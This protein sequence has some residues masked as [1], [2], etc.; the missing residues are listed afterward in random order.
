MGSASFRTLP[1]VGLFLACAPAEIGNVV[2]PVDRAPEVRIGVAL[3]LPALTLG[4]GGAILLRTPSGETL[5][6]L[7][8]Q[9][10]VPVTAGQQGLRLRGGGSL[11]FP[12][13]ELLLESSEAQGTVRL[14]GREYRG[15]FLISASSGGVRAVNLVDLEEYL[16]G[17][18]GAEMGLRGESE[19]EALRAQA[20]ASRTFAV[21]ALGRWRTRGYDLVST[22]ADQAYAGVGFEY[23]LA[24]QAVRET[25]GQVVSWNDAPIDA[26]FHSTCGGRTA[27]GTEV[28]PNADRPYLRSIRD[29][30]AGGR[31]WCSISPRFRW[32]ESWTSEELARTLAATLPAAGGSAALGRAVRELTIVGRTATGRVAQLDLRGATGGLRV[33]GPVARL[34]LRNREGAMLRSAD[35]QLQITRSGSRIVQ[36]IASG[37]GA[38]HGVGMCQWGALARSRAGFSYSDILSA[39]FPG[40]Q[41]TR[42]Y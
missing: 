35:F 24:S 17:V 37:T 13:I 19:L 32:Q 15:R 28:F 33:S 8:A 18:V 39:Y 11:E 10:S 25:R 14:Q 20:V 3:D 36:L 1:L 21:R 23:P 2:I 31:A 12:G 7:P 22:V 42:S 29:E 16:A 6:E 41:I 40:T 38:G 4:G 9:A 27:D 26:F 5:G 30:D 34:I